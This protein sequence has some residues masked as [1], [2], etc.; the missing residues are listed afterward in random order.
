VLSPVFNQVVATIPVGTSPVGVAVNSTGSTVY[1]T[2]SFDNTVSV[3]NVATNTVVGTVP[4]G[5]NPGAVVVS[6]NIAYVANQGSNSVSMINTSSNNVVGNLSV[7]AAPDALAVNPK[8]TALY[9]A[10]AGNNDVSVIS[11]PNNKAD[12]INIPVGSGPAG[13]AV[14]PTNGTVYV[15]NLNSNNV[16][17]INP[18][19]HAVTATIAVGTEPNGLVVDPENRTVYV[20]D[21]SNAAVSEIATGV[22]DHGGFAASRAA[23]A[24]CEHLAAPWAALATGFIVAAASNA[25]NNLPVGLNAGE[26]L[27]AMHASAH[28]AAAALIGINLGPNATVNGSLATLLWLGIVR[29]ANIAI[30][31]L[32]FARIGVLVTIPALVAALVL[33]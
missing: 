32:G 22:D 2:N 29:R 23:L 20:V 7:G 15:T 14:D 11:I 3:I 17:V 21:S 26:T 4:V 31:P 8:G 33:L 5:N 6:G 16:S 25:I 27:P 28:T 24:W 13:V 30:S 10:N 18:T 19:T 1:V 9:V 12:V